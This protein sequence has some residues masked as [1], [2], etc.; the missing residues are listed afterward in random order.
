MNDDK[1]L[2]IKHY[3]YIVQCSDGTLYTGWTTDITGRIKAHN[4]NTGAKYT[5]GRGPVHLL[6]SEHYKLKSDALKRENQ[7]KKM[8]RAK[9]IVLIN[10]S[11]KSV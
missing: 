10:Q 1:I 6:Y 3:V 7:I 11:N 4:N 9:K 8:T 5:K 2:E